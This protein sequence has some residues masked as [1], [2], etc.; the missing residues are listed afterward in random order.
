MAENIVHNDL[1]HS[2]GNLVDAGGHSKGKD[3]R[4]VGKPRDQHG[5]V[6]IH[7][8]ESGEI[9]DHQNSGNDLPCDCCPG[10]AFDP[11]AKS[12]DK[13]RIQDSVD[14]GSDQ[15]AGH[16][17]SR[18]SV[19]ADQVIAANGKHIKRKS[20]GSDYHVVN[21]VWHNV[22]CSAEEV[23]QRFQEQKH[24]H[25]D[26]SAEDCKGRKSGSCDGAGLFFPACTH[27][28]VI[29]GRTSDSQEKSGCSGNDGY[30]KCNVGGCISKHSNSLPDKDLVNYVVKCTDQHTDHCRNGEFGDQAAY[31]C[32]SQ[33]IFILGDSCLIVQFFSFFLNND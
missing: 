33:R 20:D 25:C 15:R 7:F 17:I 2:N 3:R 8:S 31:W 24:D 30:R 28:Q 22:R 21:G 4:Q 18:A 6:K 1:H 23:K 9:K 29:V 14:N 12:E 13:K 10:C 26:H 19:C 16:G 5:T 11:P 32:S 27:F